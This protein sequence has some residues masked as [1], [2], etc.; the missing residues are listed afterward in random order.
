MILAVV[1]P[2]LLILLLAIAPSG[3]TPRGSDPGRAAAD[4]DVLAAD[5]SAADEGEWAFD[6]LEL[7][8]G[9]VYRGLLQAEREA[10]LEFAE[11]FR[12]P[13]KPMFAV[14]RPVASDQVVKKT[15]TSGADRER[16]LARFQQFRNRARIEAGRMEDVTLRQVAGVEGD[17]WRYDGPWFQLQSTADETIVRRCVVRAEQIFRAYRQL[18]PPN[19]Q[20]RTDLRLLIFGSRDEYQ[21]HL[22]EYGLAFASPAW[23]SRTE[24]LVIAGGEF[25]A[26]QRRLRQTQAQNAEVRRQYKLLKSSFPQRLAPLIEQ[27]QQRGYSTAQIEQEVKLRSAAWQREYDEAMKRLDLA[28]AQNEALFA[29]VADQMFAQLYHEAFHAYVENY[30]CPQRGLTLPLWLNEGLAQIFETGQLEADSLRIDAPDRRRLAE[31]QDDLRGEQ[32]LAIAEVVAADEQ[33]FL[34]PS[35]TP[36]AQRYY[37]YS[38]GLAYYLAFEQNR[39]RPA[40]LAAFLRNPD[41]FGPAA[42]LTQWIDMPLAKFE[43]QWREAML[44]MRPF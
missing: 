29:Q 20:D 4:P 43:R 36:S 40:V 19:R 38:W 14:I 35:S 34:N 30:V 44:A 6:V 1:S 13:G 23:F 39:F 7:Q 24:N 8:D 17:S 25:N 27:L 16:L 21:R 22:G 3:A 32:P 2:H 10:E 33:Q 28:A 5:V 26:F 37:L 42:R 31:L 18:L 41:G 12:P 9:S 15:L 11:I